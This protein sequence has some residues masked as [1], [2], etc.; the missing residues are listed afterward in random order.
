[1]FLYVSL[2]CII[3]T[4]VLFVM[5]PLPPSTTLTEALFPSTPLLRSIIRKAGE[6]EDIEF[7]PP[8][9]HPRWTHPRYI[10]FLKESDTFGHL[11]VIVFRVPDGIGDRKDLIQVANLYDTGK[12]V[13]IRAL[14]APDLKE[15]GRAH[16]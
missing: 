6:R 5:T 4:A 3:M 9:D 1:M 13:E 15:I 7:V 12:I 2:I 14:A 16:V 11:D 10:D 8:F